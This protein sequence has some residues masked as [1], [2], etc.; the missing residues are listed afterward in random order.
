MPEDGLDDNKNSKRH[1][2]TFQCLLWGRMPTLLQRP[3]RPQPWRSVTSGDTERKHK[4]SC[5]G[6]MFKGANFW[7][8]G[9]GQTLNPCRVLIPEL[10]RERTLVPALWCHC[11]DY[12]TSHTERLTRPGR[13]SWGDFLLPGPPRWLWQQDS[14][15][16]HGVALTQP[17][18]CLIFLPFIYFFNLFLKKLNHCCQGLQP[19]G[20]SLLGWKTQTSH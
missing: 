12:G 11:E 9:P 6:W 5:L 17:H 3:G 20:S 14:G 16:A 19:L 7:D 10:Q 4:L 13:V 2:T 18:F 8:W 1:R 15:S